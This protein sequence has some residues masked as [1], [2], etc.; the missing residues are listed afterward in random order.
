[1]SRYVDQRFLNN[2]DD[3]SHQQ[4]NGACP[5]IVNP[6]GL[7]DFQYELEASDSLPA[8]DGSDLEG[9]FADAQDFEQASFFD[10]T[11]PSAVPANQQQ[12]GFFGEPLLTPVFAAEQQDFSGVPQLTPLP[13]PQQQVDVFG[14]VEPLPVFAGDQRG[15]NLGTTNASYA[16]FDQQQFAAVPQ[17][18]PTYFAQHNEGVLGPQ[19]P[20]VNFP[21]APQQ[22]EGILAPQIPPLDFPFVPQQQAQ[23]NVDPLLSLPQVPMAPQAPS[24]PQEA[25]AEAPKARGRPRIPV[26]PGSVRDIK[27][28]KN[29]E[30]AMR[31]RQKRQSDMALVSKMLQDEAQ[32]NANLRAEYFEEQQG[33]QALI[34][35]LLPVAHKDP[36]IMPKIRA[37]Q[38]KMRKAAELVASSALLDEDPFSSEP[39]Q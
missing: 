15:Q 18:A 6:V 32:H 7:Q 31:T 27:L 37:V 29:R 34:D 36:T 20:P 2:S 4:P 26:E 35:A 24:I 1:M 9:F 3:F 23:F 10:A 21:F 30:S 33:L 38:A 13:A 5:P 25:N 14:A 12:Q 16:F 8:F 11:Q 19:I 39:A 17:S 22:G 28:Q